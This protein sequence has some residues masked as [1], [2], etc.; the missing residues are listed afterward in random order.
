MTIGAYSTAPL[1]AWSGWRLRIPGGPVGGQYHGYIASDDIV[2]HYGWPAGHDE[3]FRP[4]DIR[5]NLGIY[6]WH[7]WDSGW[8]GTPLREGETVSDMVYRSPAELRP[9]PNASGGINVVRAVQQERTP[10]Y[11]VAPGN[12]ATLGALPA[13][14]VNDPV[15]PA[16]GCAGPRFPLSVQTLPPASPA[17][18][19]TVSQPPPPTTPQP[20]PTV[21]IGPAGSNGCGVGQY[22]DAAGNCTSDWRHPYAMYLPLDTA[23]TPAPT[24]QASTSPTGVCPT[25]YTTDAYGNCVVAGVAPQG[26]SIT[27]WLGSS[28]AIGSVVVPNL[29]LFGGLLLVAMKFMHK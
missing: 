25:G 19:P 16:W 27:A 17:P 23:I 12:Y 2:D 24:V 14:F 7:R 4:I 9:R 28:T 6:P 5:Q 20:S 13:A 3:T 21:A 15:C 11:A 22:R 26:S 10:G 29:V 1:L 18:A 8:H